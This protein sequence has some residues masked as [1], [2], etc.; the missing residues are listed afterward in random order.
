MPDI[1]IP[2]DTSGYTEL[3]STLTI[4]GVLNEMLYNHLVRNNKKFN[5]AEEIIRNFVLS[6]QDIK[7]IIQIASARKIKTDLTQLKTSR[8]EIETQLKALFARYHFGEEGYY[9]ALNSGDQ[10]ISRSLEVFKV[11]AL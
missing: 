3:Y 2:V 1:F 6:D 4:K 8:D 7:K 11:S 9:K 5:S 10:A